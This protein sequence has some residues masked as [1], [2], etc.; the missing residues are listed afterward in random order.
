MN[1]EPSK[2]VVLV[3]DFAEHFKGIPRLQKLKEAETEFNGKT[4]DKT[5]A[6]LKPHEAIGYVVTNWICRH[7]EGC[8]CAVR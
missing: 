5:I 4:F 1:R 3:P 2:F 8:H 6:M 7:K